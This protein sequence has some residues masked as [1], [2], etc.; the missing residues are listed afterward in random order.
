MAPW[1]EA[2]IGGSSVGT[3]DRRRT[4]VWAKPRSSRSST[5]AATSARI[6]LRTTAAVCGCS[7]CRKFAT[8]GAGVSF[9][10]SQTERTSLRRR[11]SISRCTSSSSSSTADSSLRAAFEPPEISGPVVSSSR[12]STITASSTSW[13]ILPRPP[14]A[15]AKRSIS[16]SDRSRRKPA[17]SSGPIAVRIIAAFSIGAG[18]CS[19]RSAGTRGFS[20]FLA[21]TSA[22]SGAVHCA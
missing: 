2:A 15:R 5:L 11:P 17:A 8:A 9:S 21:G 14:M 13:L 7:P 10:R 4:M 22:V 16:G 20:A 1:I 19:P 3:R 6:S 18:I 12:N